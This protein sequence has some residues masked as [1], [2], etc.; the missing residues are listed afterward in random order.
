M[1][2]NF[3]S[4]EDKMDIILFSMFLPFRLIVSTFNQVLPNLSFCLN[5]H[6]NSK[7]KPMGS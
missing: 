7:S 1:P 3:F 2:H 6:K 4:K 5:D